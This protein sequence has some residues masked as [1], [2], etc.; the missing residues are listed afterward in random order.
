METIELGIVDTR[1]IL[2]LLQEKHGYDFSDFALTAFKRRIERA[3]VIT[4]SRS[5]EIFLQRIE[6]D[7][8]F[9]E[10]L[11]HDIHVDSTEMFRDPSLWRWLRDDFF[12]HRTIPLPTKSGYRRP[13]RAMNFSLS[14]FC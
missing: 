8:N 5:V 7:K 4:E 10:N 3:M 1:N 11:V 9:V 12:R 2:K 13:Y 14:Q 6:R